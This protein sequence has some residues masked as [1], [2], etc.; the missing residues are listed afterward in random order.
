M[1][2]ETEK[3]Y[4]REMN[5]NDFNALSAVISDKENMCHYVRP[6][7]EEGVRRWIRRIMI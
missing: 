5:M 6:Y 4:L 7:D 3:L 2:I 1:I